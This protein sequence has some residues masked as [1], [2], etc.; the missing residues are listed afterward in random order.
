MDKEQVIETLELAI[1]WLDIVAWEDSTF[2]EDQSR[3]SELIER[4][5]GVL[6]YVNQ[7]TSDEETD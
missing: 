3:V 7:E 2:L 6:C 4:L 1:E 5:N